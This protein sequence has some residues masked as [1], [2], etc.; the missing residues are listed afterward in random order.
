MFS[1][2]FLVTAIASSVVHLSVGGPLDCI[3]GP[4][5][6][7]EGVGKLKLE[8]WHHPIFIPFACNLIVVPSHPNKIP[9]QSHLNATSQES[10]KE[11]GSTPSGPIGGSTSSW[12]FLL[13][14]RLLENTGDHRQ[15][16]TFTVLNLQ[17]IAE[18]TKG[19]DIS[20]LHPLGK[21]RL[22]MMEHTMYLMPPTSPTSP[23]GQFCFHQETSYIWQ[24]FISKVGP[25][26][27]TA[28]HHLQRRAESDAGNAKCEL[29]FAS[30]SV[31][32]HF[33]KRKISKKYYF[34][35]AKC[36][37]KITMLFAKKKYR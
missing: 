31:L 8:M 6:T 17:H 26:L 33:H 7:V 32:V 15:N 27:S 25:C 10:C 24:C 18:N 14:R 4:C 3:S 22:S 35:I 20:D 36:K 28:W 29:S 11:A 19:F 2:S 13:V 9:E 30:K 12:G 21:K 16:I 37:C 34:S 5:V 1:S 23:T